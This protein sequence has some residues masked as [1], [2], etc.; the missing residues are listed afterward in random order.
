M[1]I[2]TC[3]Y[4]IYSTTAI[5]QPPIL[6]SSME[7]QVGDIFLNKYLSASRK[8]DVLQLWLLLERES[9]EEG[10]YWSQVHSLCSLC[11]HLSGSN[12][13]ITTRFVARQHTQSFQNS[14]CP[15]SLQT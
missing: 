6:H 5:K 14:F 3:W 15:F 8:G 9:K 1:G 13:H 11:P 7:L 4:S 10:Y 2:A 12:R